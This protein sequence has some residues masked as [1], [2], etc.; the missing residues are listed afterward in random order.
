M[1]RPDPKAPVNAALASNNTPAAAGLRR[2]ALTS[3]LFL[4]DAAEEPRGPR[5]EDKNQDADRDRVAVRRGEI[6]HA[7][8]LGG[9]DQQSPEPGAGNGADPAED[10]G[11]E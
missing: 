6:A 2:K 4:R 8:A 9:P 3:P 10:R 7:H 1:A 11:D 5:E